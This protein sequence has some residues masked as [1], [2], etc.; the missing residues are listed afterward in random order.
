[1]HA[2]GIYTWAYLHQLGCAQAAK[3]AAYVAELEA[4]GLSRDRA[5]EAAQG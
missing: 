5:G 2:T 3:W 4:K 1:M